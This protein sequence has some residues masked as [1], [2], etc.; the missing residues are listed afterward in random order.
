M[1]SIPKKEKI[2]G[3]TQESGDRK[4][5][6]TEN[7]RNIFQIEHPLSA[8]KAYSLQYGNAY[9]P[10]LQNIR[11]RQRCLFRSGYLFRSTHPREHDDR[12]RNGPLCHN[13]SGVRCFSRHPC[14]GG[15]S[16]GTRRCTGAICGRNR[17]SR[18]PG[19][20][21]S[22]KTRLEK[23]DRRFV[24]IGRYGQQSFRPE[25]VSHRTQL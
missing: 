11:P 4:P 6:P 12:I 16:S 2:E 1:H 15:N 7:R 13:T 21:K 25:K 9:Q 22:R 20:K 8:A 3:R 19:R 10:Y 17:N 23:I 18:Q 24:E 14:T 5:L